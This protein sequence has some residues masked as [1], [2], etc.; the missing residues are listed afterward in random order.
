G[1]VTVNPGGSADPRWVRSLAVSPASVIGGSSATGSVTIN[2][3]ATVGGTIVQLFTSAAAAS[4][5]AS[6]TV[7]GGATNAS[8]TVTTTSVSSNTGVTIWAVLNVT[9]AAALTVTAPPAP[10]LT[11]GTPTLLSPANDATP[12]QPIT[13]DWTDVGNAASYELQIDDNDTF[14]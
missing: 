7:P 1:S 5:P 9:M 11:P 8:F 14:T 6:V 13:F 3:P 4:V 10:P 2:A 12:A